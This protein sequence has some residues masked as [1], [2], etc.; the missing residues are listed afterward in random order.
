VS[1]TSKRESKLEERYG[2]A[3]TRTITVVHDFDVRIP[4]AEFRID[5][6]ETDGPIRDKAQNY[7]QE[8]AGDKAGLIQGVR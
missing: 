7:Q 6:N 4:P 1:H 8:N 2:G 5:D 3:P